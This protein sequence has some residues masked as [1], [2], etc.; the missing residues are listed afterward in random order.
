M[1]YDAWFDCN[2]GDEYE[3]YDYTT[4]DEEDWF[5][6]FTTATRAKKAW[7]PEMCILKTEVKKINESD[8]YSWPM[9]PDDP[10]NQYN[11]KRPYYSE[12]LSAFTEKPEEYLE[13]F[14]QLNVRWFVGTLDGKSVARRQ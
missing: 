9:G 6:V 2:V 8:W 10:T 5:R 7:T 13:R 4:M 11:R 12:Y 14:A 3:F 1:N